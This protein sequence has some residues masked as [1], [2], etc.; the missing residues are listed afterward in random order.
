MGNSGYV[1]NAPQ[2]AS[3]L[4]GIEFG[5]LWLPAIC[6]A[7]SALPVLFYKKFELLEP[8]IQAELK[9]RREKLAALN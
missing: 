9:A 7:L 1:P 8:Q 2:T 5:F 3:A 4:G 6:L